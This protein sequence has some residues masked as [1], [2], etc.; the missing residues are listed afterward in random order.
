MSLVVVGGAC[1]SLRRHMKQAITHRYL[2][3]ETFSN[4]TNFMH[5]QKDNMALIKHNM[6][7][8]KIHRS[9][10]SPGIPYLN[11][12]PCTL[13]TSATETLNPQFCG[14]PLPKF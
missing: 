4:V 5:A 3:D 7:P 13:L 11:P 1:L 8:G 6:Q 2:E 9:S 10:P 14:H 12:K